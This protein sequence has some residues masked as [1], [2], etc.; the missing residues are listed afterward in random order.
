MVALAPKPPRESE[1]FKPFHR[2]FL[3]LPFLAR[4]LL[5]KARNN[6]RPMTSTVIPTVTPTMV[7]TLDLDWEDN[8]DAGDELGSEALKGGDA[9]ADGT[10]V[11]VRVPVVEL[12]STRQEVL[13]PVKT[14]KGDELWKM[15]S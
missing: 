6:N 3:E 9:D 2:L 15:L 12:M 5:H 14:K 4:D 8:S 13:V 10:E 1:K 7:G 11:G